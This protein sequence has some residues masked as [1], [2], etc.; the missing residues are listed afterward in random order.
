MVESWLPIL[1]FVI[2]TVCGV[3][4]LSLRRASGFFHSVIAVLGL[5]GTFAISVAI[6]VEVMKGNVLV[7][8]NNTIYADGLSA[9]MELLGSCMGMVVAIYSIRYIPIHVAHRADAPQRLST[10][11]G[12]LLLFLGM[13]NWTCVTN[14]IVWLYV[15]L[16][17]TT[18]A[19]VFL[20]TFYWDRRSLEA[21][22]KYL[23]LVTVGIIFSL[24]GLVLIYAGVAGLPEMKGRDVLLITELSRVGRKIPYSV[25]LLANALLVAG[26]GAKAGLVP[27]HAWLP[28]AHAEAPAPV[29]ALLSGIVIKVGAYAIAR[30]VTVFAPQYPAVIIF[31][32][33][34]ASLSMVIGI[35]MALVQD[36]IKRMLAYSSVSQIGYVV[37]G[38]GFGTY[39]GIYGGL[40][41]LVNH[42]IVKALLFLA[43]GAVAHVTGTRRLS[44]L[45]GLVHRMPVVAICFFIG[46]LAIGGLPPFS[47]FMSKFTL[48]AAAADLRLTWAAVIAVFTGLLTVACFVRAALRI[49][50][51]KPVE[52]IQPAVAHANGGE[53][54][55][56]MSM[57]LPMLLLALLTVVIG[58]YPGLIHPILDR[59]TEC[60]LKVLTGGF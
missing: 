6:T 53:R 5:T 15:T 44:E 18:L 32:A 38:L 39:L 59:A 3:I 8:L 54:S 20:V 49:F 1:V 22:Y 34:M 19:T 12:L 58:F 55:V 23:M 60:I 48:F 47:L 24:F 42:T 28:D 17:A 21:G 46:A 57:V 56:P 43:A 26:F 37:E 2:P 36:D 10:Y 45:G 27:F 16:E 31:V 30:I 14:S 4:S 50:W 9:L 51:G 35:L 13:M 7:A 25:V 41:H 29:S 11:Y 40:F 52:A 33:I